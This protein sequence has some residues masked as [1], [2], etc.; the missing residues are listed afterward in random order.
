MSVFYENPYGVGGSV[1]NVPEISEP[2]PAI[3]AVASALPPH[4]MDQE[5]LTAALRQLWTRNG[6]SSSHFDRIQRALGISGRYLPLTIDE[7]VGLD[8]FAKCNDAWLRHAPKLAEAAA[9]DALARAGLDARDIDHLFLATGTGI[10]TPSVDARLA[11]RLGMRH[12]L[13]RTPIFGL[14]CAGGAAAIGRAA[15]Y[16]RAFPDQAAMAVSVE[17][18]SLTLQREDLSV[19]NMIASGLFGD[20]AAAVILCG[21]GRND[22][23]GPR[24]IASHSAFYAETERAIGWDLIESGFKIVLSPQ[25]PELVRTHLRAEV[26]QLLREHSLIRNDISHWIV[27]PGGPKML[28]A[29][30]AALELPDGALE[31]SW[32]LMRTTGNLSSA[33]VLFILAEVTNAQVGKAGEWGI[34]LAMG[35]GFSVEMALLRW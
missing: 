10:A 11:N 23:A 27:H 24:V 15:D 1:L 7:Y 32:R 34:L 14:G 29:V 33:S 8:S 17:L 28:N 16:V 5:T 12:M 35:P 30:E 31:R 6:F 21:S 3:K 25:L 20:G 26:D 19:A 9:R 22:C 4:Y 2:R 18:C 13:K